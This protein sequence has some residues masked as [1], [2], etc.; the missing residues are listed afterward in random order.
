[1]E[2]SFIA[3]FTGPTSIS[4]IRG[5]TASPYSWEHLSLDEIC[6]TAKTSQWFGYRGEKHNNGRTSPPAQAHAVS[7]RIRRM[8]IDSLAE[9]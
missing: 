4:E 5:C 3:V 7:S 2:T 6:I 1:M 9:L 8:E